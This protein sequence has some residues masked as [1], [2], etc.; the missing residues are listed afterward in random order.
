MCL[1]FYR[2]TNYLICFT[3][4]FRAGGRNS[5]GR[6]CL[7]REWKESLIDKIGS[8]FDLFSGSIVDYYLKTV[9]HA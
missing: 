8:I 9:D 5:L 2:V 7:C 6:A 1:N 3:R 4:M